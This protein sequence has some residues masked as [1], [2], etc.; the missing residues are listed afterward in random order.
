M[1]P[2]ESSVERRAKRRADELGVLNA[3]LTPQGQRAYPDRMFFVPG[4]RP[5]LIEF[6]QEGERPT[7]LQAYIQKRLRAA[8]YDVRWTD[9]AEQAI[10]WLEE[11]LRGA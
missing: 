10:A 1:K 11:R 5:L 7:K 2:L 8:G 3:K 4:G 6:K 9:S